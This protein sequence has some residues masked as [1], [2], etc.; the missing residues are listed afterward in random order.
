MRK[1]SIKLTLVLM[2]KLFHLL[3]KQKENRIKISASSQITS[4]NVQF[5]HA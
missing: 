5:I 2:A 1:E 4:L 3:C